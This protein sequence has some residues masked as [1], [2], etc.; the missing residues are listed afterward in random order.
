MGKVSDKGKEFGMAPNL[1]VA[2]TDVSGV[3]GVRG[4]E[5]H[6]TQLGSFMQAVEYVVRAPCPAE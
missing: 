6:L 5:M 2:V 1:S 4:A 3:F